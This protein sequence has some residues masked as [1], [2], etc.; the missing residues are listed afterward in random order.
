VPTDTPD[1]H[2]RAAERR[3]DIARTREEIARAVTY[4]A[5]RAVIARDAARETDAAE[6]DAALEGDDRAQQ[7]MFEDV[8]AILARV[9]SGIAG[10]RTAMDAL[11]DRLSSAA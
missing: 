9:E 8:D 11:L 2:P 3:L 4:D 6:T 10:E 5:A 1:Q 7:S